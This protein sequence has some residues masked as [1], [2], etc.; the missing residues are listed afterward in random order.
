MTA[1]DFTEL[2]GPT[3]HSKGNSE[4]ATTTLGTDGKEYVALYFTASW[5]P[6]CRAFTPS[7]VDYYLL[8]HIQ[9]K[10]DIVVISSD[11]E[12]SKHD[13]YFAKMPFLALPY[14]DRD[15]KKA[16][17]EKYNVKGI[18][19]LILL[20]T[21]TGEIA[22]KNFI[23]LVKSDPKGFFFPYP[24]KSTR[25][26]LSK[27]DTVGEHESFNGKTLALYFD[28]TSFKPEFWGKC[29][30]GCGTFSNR[31][32][33]H[34]CNECDYFVACETCF[35]D[36]ANTHD[37]E[38]TFKTRE[39][40]DYSKHMQPMRPKS[41]W[42]T[43]FHLAR[44][45]EVEYE[46]TTIVIV[47]PA[48]VVLNKNASLALKKGQ[49]F[50]FAAL[51]P[52]VIVFTESFLLVEN[53]VKAVAEKLVPSGAQ[54][55]C[56]DGPA[57]VGDEV[58]PDAIIYDFQGGRNAFAFRGDLTEESLITFVEDFK[59]GKLLELKGQE[60]K[61]KELREKEEKEKEAKKKEEDEKEE[62]EEEVV[63]RPTETESEK[64]WSKTTKTTTV[65]TK[66]ENGSKVTTVTE[67]VYK[68]LE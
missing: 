27:V 4:V 1:F 9:E 47:D 38:H 51:K 16:L 45:Y 22:I 25:L 50:P 18:P 26:V 43:A 58:K 2:L 5:C 10:L 33:R 8:A 37:K 62:K 35:K 53:I 49:K 54:V 65:T 30:G 15:R 63:V 20:S 52:A 6:P 21:A 66:A 32:I 59:S 17:A 42:P 3:L 7:L 11:R 19:T 40:I 39:P 44:N 29:Y 12:E 48:R 13:E 68:L 24:E 46:A 67:T 61:E 36:I 41:Q 55:Q 64:T 23:P 60:T 14:V 56:T 34:I 57:G 31:G 28:A